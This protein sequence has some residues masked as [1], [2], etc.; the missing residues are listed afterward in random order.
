MLP[1]AVYYI[2]Y[3]LLSVTRLYM[4]A[5]EIGRAHHLYNIRSNYTKYKHRGPL[6]VSKRATKSLHMY[7][8]Q[9]AAR[10]SKFHYIHAALLK[11]LS[12]VMLAHSDNSLSVA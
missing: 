9:A 10:D 3:V 12:T 2:G 7:F 11:H 8:R 4:L 1:T 5:R 6:Y